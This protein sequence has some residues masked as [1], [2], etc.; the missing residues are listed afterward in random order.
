MDAISNIVLQ[1]GFP[2]VVILVLAAAYYRKDLACSKLQEDRVTESKAAVGALRD[3]AA[4][5]NR[6]CD[7]LNVKREQGT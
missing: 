4:A 7:L 3:A 1:Y 5:T 2:G 6:L